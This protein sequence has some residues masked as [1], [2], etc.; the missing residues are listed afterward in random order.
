MKPLYI[1]DLDGTLAHIEHRKH[2]LEDKLDPNRW[3]RFYAACDK[4][5]PCA[6]VI[7]TMNSLR[8]AGCEVWI[9]SGRSSEVREKTVAW[10]CE[11]TAFTPHELEIALTMRDEGDYTVDDELKLSWLN[12]MLIDDRNR[13]VA[14]FDDRNRVV[15]MWRDAG[16]TC[17]Q[18]APGEF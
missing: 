5:S 9:F 12:E 8:I 11:H 10:L 16:V 6:A 2:M 14:V 1:F 4:D 3:R 15:Q 7:N 13:L 17:F 18:V